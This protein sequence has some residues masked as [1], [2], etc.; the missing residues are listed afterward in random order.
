MRAMLVMATSVVLLGAFSALPASAQDHSILLAKLMDYGKPR[1]ATPI[2]VL[3]KTTCG[4][5]CGN[6]L[7][8]ATCEDGQTCSCSCGQK[9]VCK[10][11]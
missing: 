7:S 6:V 9:P 1:N 3:A 8:E 10:C 4:T 2:P 5:Y 11:E